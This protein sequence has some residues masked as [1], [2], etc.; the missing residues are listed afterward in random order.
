LQAF[1][2]SRTDCG[3]QRPH[4]LT[5]P[6]MTEARD[7]LRAASNMLEGVRVLFLSAGY[8]A[9]ARLLQDAS[10]LVSDEVAAL[11]KAIGQGAK[12]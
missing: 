1:Y 2:V 12:P 7:K 5:L 6:E 3:K 9:G 11:D 4:M 10:G 8:V